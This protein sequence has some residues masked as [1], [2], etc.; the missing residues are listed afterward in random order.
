MLPYS[1]VEPNNTQQHGTACNERAHQVYLDV[2]GTQILI[3]AFYT[4]SLPEFYLVV[5]FFGHYR[6]TTGENFWMRWFFMSAT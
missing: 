3:P 2:P 4:A 1:L 5:L 6:L